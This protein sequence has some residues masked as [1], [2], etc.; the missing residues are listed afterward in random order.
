MLTM[1]QRFVAI[2]RCFHFGILPY[3]VYEKECHYK[4]NGEGM[5]VYT[6]IEHLHINLLTAKSL[7]FKTEHPCTHGFHK[8][9]VKYF[10]KVF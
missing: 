4:K 6:Y 1:K 8:C 10:R 2:Y 9:K 3:W 5:D 7:L